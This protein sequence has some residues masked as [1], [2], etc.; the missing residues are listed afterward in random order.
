MRGYCKGLILIPAIRSVVCTPQA[1]ADLGNQEPGQIL[2][3]Y[4]A[5]WVYMSSVTS[6]GNMAVGLTPIP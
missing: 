6:P 1:M 3:R 2:A 5:T 4:C